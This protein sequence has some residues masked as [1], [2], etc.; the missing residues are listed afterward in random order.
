MTFRNRIEFAVT[1]LLF[2]AAGLMSCGSGTPTPAARATPSPAPAT[3]PVP[4]PTTIAYDHIALIILE[5]QSFETVIGS[6]EAPYLN[7]LAN[8]W[9]LATRYS[10]VSHPSLPN[11]LALIGGSTYGITQDCTDC[12]V[13]APSLPDRL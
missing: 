7:S 3:T 4:S 9:A 5:N 8:Q 10:G 2:A 11:Y 6:A 1:S 12:V 13:N